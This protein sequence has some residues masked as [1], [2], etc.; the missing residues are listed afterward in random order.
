MNP[1]RK[2]AK[3][4]FGGD[5]YRAAWYVSGLPREEMRRHS[6]TMNT[7]Q[8]QMLLEV[9]NHRELSNMT[10]TQRREELGR[11]Y[12]R[13]K[14][15]KMLYSR[16]EFLEFQENPYQ[17]P[18]ILRLG[19]LLA[20]LVIPTVVLFW[21]GLSQTVTQTVVVLFALGMV[22]CAEAAWS[23]VTNF[24]KFRRYRALYQDIQG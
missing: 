9:V 8:L 14:K 5:E 20:C 19:L 24:L 15:K 6:A 12:I 13:N 10:E 17:K 3:A 23:C 18:M 16:E 7:R 21:G 11:D 4:Q 2:Y 22:Y 1:F